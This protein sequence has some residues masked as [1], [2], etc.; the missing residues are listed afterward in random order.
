MM[1]ISK[2]KLV[3]SNEFKL[4]EFKRFGLDLS[5]E[6]GLDLKEVD[7]TSEEVVI[8]KALEA[9][10]GKLVEDTILMID[11]KEVVD[12]RNKIDEMS[13][14]E[15]SDAQWIVSLA[16]LQ[17]GKVHIASASVKGVIRA[18][19]INPEDSF[20]FDAYFQPNDCKDNLSLYQLELA[21]EKD[22]YSARKKA[23]NGFLNQS[24]L[25]KVIEEKDISK[26]TGSYQKI[27]H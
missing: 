12:I 15:E 24:D 7:G 9:G 23:I 14:F 22:N 26:W 21:G 16:L 5:I 13:E 20:G 10:E 25:F 3:T 2:A 1:D 8:Y 19:L 18:S 17:D 6:K 4:R 27:D 11:G